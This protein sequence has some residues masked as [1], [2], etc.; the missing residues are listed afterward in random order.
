MQS[1]QNVLH[2]VGTELSLMNSWNDVINGAAGFCR[3]DSVL[4]QMTEIRD[5][6][7]RLRLL[8]AQVEYCC[9]ALCW[10]TEALSQ[11]ELVGSSRPPPPPRE[12]SALSPS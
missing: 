1:T 5:H 9:S 12:V 8:E 6:D 4:K 2:H 10:M 7:R 11:S 3:V